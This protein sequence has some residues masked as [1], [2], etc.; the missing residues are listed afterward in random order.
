[1]N[2]FYVY[3]HT[4][5]GEDI[6]FYIGKGKGN[7][8][9]SKKGR[10]A[11][12]NRVAKN[13]FKVELEFENLDEKTA[14]QMEEDLIKMWGRRNIDTGCLVNLTDG[15][16]GLSGYIMSDETKKKLSEISKSHPKVLE[17]IRNARIAN[18]GKPRS[19]ETRRKIGEGNFNPSPEA[20]EKMRQARLGKVMPEESKQRMI[21]KKVVYEYRITAPDGTSITTNSMKEFC[22]SNKLRSR[23]MFFVAHGKLPNY[24][25]YTVEIIKKLKQNTETENS[26]ENL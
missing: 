4:K 2:N 18:T 5:I 9:Y 21:S 17:G 20:R 12:W 7:R 23:S 8:A 16:E 6:P 25:G 26:T 1:M 15:G 24:K 10:S 11:W 13:G 19:E 22:R 14:F 3:V